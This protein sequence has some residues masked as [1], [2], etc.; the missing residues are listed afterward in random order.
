MTI[1]ERVREIVR[2]LEE[3]FPRYMARHREQEYER[4][5]E[6]AEAEQKARRD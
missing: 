3:D 6:M 5:R 1:D 4:A 2:P